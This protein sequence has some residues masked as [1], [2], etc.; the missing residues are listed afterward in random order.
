MKTVFKLDVSGVCVR[1]FSEFHE[2]LAHV[3]APVEASLDGGCSNFRT[4]L[5]GCHSI[6]TNCLEKI[7]EELLCLSL[8]LLRINLGDSLALRWLYRIYDFAAACQ[9]KLLWMRLERQPHIRLWNKWQLCSNSLKDCTAQLILTR[10]KYGRHMRT[11]SLLNMFPLLFRPHGKMMKKFCLED[12]GGSFVPGNLLE[13]KGLG[14]DKCLYLCWSP[15]FT[16]AYLGISIRGEV[17][18]WKEH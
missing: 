13:A 9:D 11:W 17:Q 14:A 5:L 10:S 4:T 15:Y 1:F 18:R 3:K 2:V 7:L 8:T 16:Q 6:M 12:P